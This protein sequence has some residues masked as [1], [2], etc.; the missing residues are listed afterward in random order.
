MPAEGWVVDL[1]ANRGLFSVWAALAGAQVVAVEAQQGFAAEIR[2]LADHNIVGHRV[3]VETGL[4]GGTRRSGG[5]VGVLAEERRWAATSHG[6]GERPPDVGVPQLMA[7]YQIGR[8]GLLKVDIEGGEFAV[9]CGGEDLRWLD[10]VGQ[11]ALEIHHDFGDAAALVRR[12]RRHGFTVDLRDNDG[13]VV[14]A[15]SPRLDYAYCHRP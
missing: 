10:R 12:L 5:T 9:F 8:I 4:A 13:Q 15:T 6:T 14:A 1:G 2:H 3:H 7:R 11:I